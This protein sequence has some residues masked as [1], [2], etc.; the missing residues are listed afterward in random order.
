MSPHVMAILGPAWGLSELLFALKTRSK[1]NAASKDRGSLALIWIVCL[2]SILLGVFV[3]EKGIGWKFPAR[4]IFYE[5]GLVVFV[6]GVVFRWYSIIYLGRFFTPNVAIVDKHQLIE[7][8]PYR[9]IRHPT[10]AG[11]LLVFLGMGLNIGNL[12]SLLI[13]MAPIVAALWWR[14][15]IE[16]A[17]MITAFGDQYRAYMQRTKRLVPLIY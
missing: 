1:S 15:R 6:A 12:A 16:E 9:F 4:R 2:I 5:T 7:A 14:M 10:Y 11:M 17:V 13:I 8:G 3:A